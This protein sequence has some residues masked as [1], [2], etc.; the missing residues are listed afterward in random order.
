[1]LYNN[2]V[3]RMNNVSNIIYRDIID[4]IESSIQISFFFVCAVVAMHLMLNCSTGGI[5][6]QR[7]LLVVVAVHH[8]R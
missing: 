6:A 2:V 3:K 7:G 8:Y 1:M 4:T 5:Q